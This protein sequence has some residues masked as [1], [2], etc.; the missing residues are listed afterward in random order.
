VNPITLS[1]IAVAS[2]IAVPAPQPKGDTE[3][4]HGTWLVASMQD[5]GEEQLDVSIQDKGNVPVQK[6]KLI[7]TF[8]KG[9][10]VVRIDGKVEGE[11]KSYKLD[12]SKSPKWIDFTDERQTYRG[13]YELDRD[14]LRICHGAPN[15]EK[16]PTKFAS[17]CES[18][19]KHLVVLKREKP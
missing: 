6:L 18:P 8:E 3:L 12:P 1:V 9:K 14:T 11:A 10:M 17:E 19:N 7:L 16:R 2:L 4:I 5:E 13:I 15:S